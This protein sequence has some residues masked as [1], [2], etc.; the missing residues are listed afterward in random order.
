[1]NVFL[2][3]GGDTITSIGTGQFS[4]YEG[5]TIGRDEPRGKRKLAERK[6]KLRKD[7]NA[8]K[9]MIGTLDQAFMRNYEKLRN[10]LDEDK[11]VEEIH[12][13]VGIKEL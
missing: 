10:A 6:R 4:M 9:V 1:M 13:Q 8:E 11:D 2:Q 5:D 12:N 3:G 7:P